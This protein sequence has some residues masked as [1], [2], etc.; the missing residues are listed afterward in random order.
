MI[1]KVFLFLV[2]NFSA[3]AIAGLF[4]GKGVASD[5]YQNLNKA[6]WTPPGWVFG[7]IWTIIMI[8]FA[9]YMAYLIK[10]ISNS[11]KIMLLFTLQWFLNVA[12][13]PIFFYYKSPLLGLVIISFL[14]L[15]L[16]YFLLNHLKTLK[17][18]SI[19]I[20]PYLLWIYIATS[21]NAYTVLYN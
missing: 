8:C 9:I 16:S 14:A 21:L 3:L 1:K 4:T 5:W 15:L 18:K 19:F 10:A 13:T 12:W 6:P 2:L 17:L 11:K 20:I 7:F